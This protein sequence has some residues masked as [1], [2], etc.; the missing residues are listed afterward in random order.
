MAGDRSLSFTELADSV[1]RIAA[2]LAAE[3]VGRGDVVSVMLSRSL[4]TVESLFGV[5]AAGAVYNPIDTEYPDERVA[6]IIEDAAPPV[7][8]T[9]SAAAA[10]VRGILAGLAIRPKLLLLEEL[11][12]AT[13]TGTPFGTPWPRSR[14]RSRIPASW[15]TSCSPPAPRAGPRESRSATVP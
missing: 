13:D 1:T 7:I 14:P 4:G 6:A 11:A 3:G 2:G 8:L 15:P 5:L 9:S 10:R 12:A